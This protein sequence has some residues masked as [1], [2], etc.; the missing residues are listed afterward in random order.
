MGQSTRPRVICIP[1]PHR[2]FPRRSNGIQRAPPTGNVLRNTRLSP[3][4]L[5]CLLPVAESFR[6]EYLTYYRMLPLALGDGR[7][8]VAVAGVPN[9]DAIED[10]RESYQADI[11]FVPVDEGDLHDAIRRVFGASESVLELV[12]DLGAE[13]ELGG[14]TGEQEPTDV[15]GL[16][17]QPPVIRFVNLLIREAHEATASDIHLEATREGLRVRLRIDGVLSDLPSPPRGLDRKS[18]V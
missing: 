8:R 13:L 9:A 5:T 15:R 12:K 3:D 7:L 6:Q 14:E 4:S 11:D 1:L 2:H 17:N 16:A 10:L 18:V